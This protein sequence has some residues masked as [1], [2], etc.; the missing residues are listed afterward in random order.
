[1]PEWEVTI[2]ET[3]MLKYRIEGGKEWAKAKALEWARSGILPDDGS[4][5]YAVE[6]QVET[7]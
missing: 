1:M 4:E 3:R 5:K 7:S 6:D 2:K